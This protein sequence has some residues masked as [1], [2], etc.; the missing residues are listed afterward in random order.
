[1]RITELTGYKARSEYIA[2]KSQPTVSQFIKQAANAGWKFYGRG[3][4]GAVMQHPGKKY[5]YKIFS[6]R[7]GNWGYLDYTKFVLENPKNPY[8]PKITKPIKL[9]NTSTT[10]FSRTSD[11]YVIRIEILTPPTGINDPKF[12]KYIDPNYDLSNTRRYHLGDDDNEDLSLFDHAISSLYYHDKNF[13]DIVD[14]ASD[15]IDFGINNV[16]FRGDQL[17]FIDPMA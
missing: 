5:L 14:Y 15:A 9:R 17:I 12:K 10:K 3:G 6:D 8:V 4:S 16:M 2:L 1:M 13:K 11:L 7:P